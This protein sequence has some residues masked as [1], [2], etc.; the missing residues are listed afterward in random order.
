[1]R[2]SIT[3][4][5]ADLAKASG[6]TLVILLDDEM[7]LALYKSSRM[8]EE[9]SRVLQQAKDEQ[10]F[11]PL[12]MCGKHFEVEFDSVVFVPLRLMYFKD[13]DDEIRTAAAKAM[14]HARKQNRT[15]LSF[16]LETKA[17]IKAAGPVCE[18]L[19]LGAYEFTSYRKS[20]YP[21]DEMTA[22]L[23]VHRD[24]LPAARALVKREELACTA[25]NRARDLINTSGSDLPPESIADYARKVA[26]Q[27]GLKFNLLKAADLKKEGYAGIMAVGAGSANPP[28]MFS[29][30]YQG[31]RRKK[32]DVA[33]VGKGISFDTGGISLKPWDKMWE[34]KTDM[35][36]AS[37][38]IHTL[39]AI[40]HLKPKLNIAA[41]VP[42]AENRPGSRAYLPGDVL[43]FKNDVSVEVHST[44][45]EGRLILADGLIHAQDKFAPETIVD[46]ATLTGACQRALGP[47][48]TGIMAND[49][50]LAQS[51][52]RAG[53]RAGEKLWELPLPVEYDE[54]LLSPIATVKNVGGPLAGAQTAGLF[55]QHFVGEGVKWAHL[56][57]AGT[58]YYDTKRRQFLQPGATGVM[59]RTLT[60][61]L[62]SR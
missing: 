51:I 49:A 16:L 13:P 34:M 29:L 25:A 5:T 54:M 22:C 61:W 46:V 37:A 57:I 28:V 53:A 26:A 20:R 45:A 35:S 56:D 18:G 38:V 7:R 27:H 17:G 55:L 6:E 3:A 23:V 52:I 2:V 40:A 39:A 12:R 9:A 14:D 32:V 33:L 21:R 42:S 15:N 8:Y 19:H 1:M 43:K 60:D 50:L 30:E 11:E 59:V 48:F 10:I 36:G 31:A 4:A 44:D 41:V 58:A 47:D 24:N 62:T